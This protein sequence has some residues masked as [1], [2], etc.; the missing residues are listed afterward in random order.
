MNRS[1]LQ[2]SPR[3]N[4]LQHEFIPQA[5]PASTPPV[6]PDPPGPEQAPPQ[7]PEGDPPPQEAP[8]DDPPPGI[9]AAQ[10]DR[11]LTLS[12]Q[13]ARAASPVDLAVAGEEDA[14]VGLEL[15][16]RRPEPGHQPP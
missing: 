3:N 1:T 6:T 9:E 5:S 11:L 8:Q 12:L 13:E 2:P 15:L 14:G 10:P 7:L 4:E 16:L